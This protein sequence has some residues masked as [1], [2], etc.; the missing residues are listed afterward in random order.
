MN[1]SITLT[2]EDRQR[3]LALLRYIENPS[4]G[5][6]AYVDA[7]EAELGRSESVQSTEISRDVVTMD[8]TVEVRDV[9]TGELDTYTLAYPNQADIS[10]SR[11][12]ILAP[13]AIAILG[14]RVGNVV[15]VRTPSGERRIRI[16]QIL[17]QPEHDGTP[18]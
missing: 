2:N 1:Q 15:T 18:V 12:S 4:S 8:S 10:K 5:L 9:A 14:N 16:E 13:V 17:F 3:L 11:I 7:L 6:T